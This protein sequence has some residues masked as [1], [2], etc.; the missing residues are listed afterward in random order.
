MESRA[1]A[2]VALSFRRGAEMTI[3]HRQ[4]KSFLILC[5]LALS[6]ALG[7]G[8]SGGDESQATETGGTGTGIS[9]G[10]TGTSSSGGAIVGQGGAIVGQG[11]AIV[12]QGGAIVG[13][14]GSIVGQGGAI[15]GQ[16]GAIVGQGGAIVGQGGAIVG[17]GGAIVGQG[18]SIVGQGGAIVGQGG[19]IVGQG[20]SIVGQGGAI[21]GQGG[22]IVGQGGSI[23]GQG[24]ATVGEGGA[25]V[26]EGGATVGEGGATVGEGGATLGEG[27]ATVGEGGATAEGGATGFGGDTG[28]GGSTGGDI[29]PD[30]IYVAPE[31]D[32]GAD[33]TLEDPTDLITAVSRVSA[34]GTIYMRGG[35]YSYGS[36]ITISK[37]GSNGS[38]ITLSA[39]PLD[40]ERPFLDF[41]SM[42]ESDSNRGVRLSGGYW[43]IYGLDL[44]GAG[45]NC[46]NVSGSNNTIEF[47]SFSECAD[48]GLQLGGGASNNLIVNC[49]SY[50]N[51]D[52]SLENADGFAAKLDV[53]SGNKFVGCRAWNNL[54]DGWDGYLRD[55]DNISTTY[56]S[57]WAIDNGKLKNGSVGEGD[58]NGFKSGGSDDKDLKHNAVFTQCIATGNV[59]D[60][61]DHNSNRGSV[62][63]LNCA[64]H[65][66]GSNIN[67]GSDNQAASL[68]V[69]NT[70]SLGTNGSFNAGTTDVTNNSW[71][72]GLSAT[73]A[74]FVSVD[75]SL[76][77]APR[78][79][80]G[81]LPD[82]DYFQLVSGSDLRN[83]GVN[84]GLPYQGSAPDLG[85][86]ESSQ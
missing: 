35:D 59:N 16:G 6:V 32:S 70:I 14:G 85:P 62:T 36:T 52:S 57:C 51:A 75:V 12:G 38:L 80:D 21:V 72:N 10:S 69:K 77:K 50:F 76:L 25:T 67:F 9:G 41:S 68:T 65:N 63:I 28:V 31:G 43:H 26:G 18:G 1:I 27:G 2:Q 3:S 24:G 49:D 5:T 60:G 56:E 44:F 74:D 64:A 33:G 58:G 22:S 45:D 19:S 54:D 23:V 13:Q 82:I 37:S 34:G 29:D 84:V 7:C 48:T 4:K 83:A 42:S 20:G 47:T 55:N 86:F 17:Q 79:S 11:G 61:F 78:K 53:G 66:N 30:A 15:V 46:M 39:Y 8:D 40:T 73:N 81:S 71:Q